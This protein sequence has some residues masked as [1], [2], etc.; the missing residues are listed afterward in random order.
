M[1]V[2]RPCIVGSMGST[3]FYETTMTGRDLA[4]TVRPAKETDAW[5]SASIEERMQRTFDVRRIRETIVPYLAKHPDRFFG[6]LVV[7]APKGAIEFEPLATLISEPLSAAYRDSARHMGF[8]SIDRGELIALDG[9]HRLLA[10]REIVAGGPPLGE[11]A[12]EAADDDVS[13][14]LIEF[15][16]PQKTRRIFNKVNRHAR[17]SSRSDN[18]VTS[19][20][21]GC[22]IVTRW[23]LDPDRNAPLAARWASDERVELV[24]WSS[25]TLGQNSRHL[26]TISAV[27]ETTRDIVR[28]EEFTGFDEKTNPVAPRDEALEAAF[29]RVAAWWR[30]ILEL[31]PLRR[32]LTDPRGIPVLRNDPGDESSLLLRPLGQ[33]ALVRGLTR[34]LDADSSLSLG[35][36]MDRANRISWATSPRSIWEGS[37]V[38]P[39]GRMCARQEAVSL[40]ADLVVHLVLGSRLDKSRHEAI[41]QAWNRARG[42]QADLPDPLGD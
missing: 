9:Q 11:Y 7:L 3:T 18:I 36:A 21:D 40:A 29:E 15:E 28:F 5:A 25:N 13:V 10:Y 20:D 39:D 24:N 41:Q 8:V 42:N 37:I 16:T 4:M 1:S 14:L 22:A 26:T 38:L 30:S 23:L 17:P 32:A 12:G 2:I 34:A 35:E 33:I 6:S 27:Y 19:E 31:R